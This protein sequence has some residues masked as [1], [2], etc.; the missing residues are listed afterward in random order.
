MAKET[1][2]LKLLHNLE[3]V[4]D[5]TTRTIRVGVL[6]RI[7]T[8]RLFPCNNEFT[9]IL[10]NY[11]ILSFKAFLLY[12]VSVHGVIVQNFLMIRSVADLL[13]DWICIFLLGITAELMGAPG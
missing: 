12:Y 6:F 10:V 1:L 13:P 5:R 11:F 7:E 8:L 4:L 2:F 3:E 9:V